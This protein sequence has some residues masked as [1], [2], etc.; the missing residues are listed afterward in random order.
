MGHLLDKHEFGIVKKHKVFTPYF[1]TRLLSSAKSP[2]VQWSLFFQERD[3]GRSAAAV[4][5]KVA[6]FGKT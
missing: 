4:R 5:S 2:S 3:L 6:I 1:Q